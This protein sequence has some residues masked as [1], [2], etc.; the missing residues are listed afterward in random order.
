M[1][2]LGIDGFDQLVPET[3]PKPGAVLL[4]VPPAEEKDQIAAQFVLEGL[5][6]G[7]VAIVL[8][9]E[10]GIRDLVRRAGNLGFDAEKSVAQGRLVPVDWEHVVA[11]KNGNHGGL[12]A[13]E[14]AV[15][16]AAGSA[17][18][19][20]TSRKYLGSTRTSLSVITSTSYFASFTKRQRLLTLLFSPKCST[21]VTK[22]IRAS[23]KSF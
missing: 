23:G 21:P 5:R 13:V 17:K 15:T 11:P 1:S 12:P 8:G 19:A 4:L 9:S 7:D 3:I 20:T 2:R 22:R 14:A 18:G 10:A 6:N 16:A